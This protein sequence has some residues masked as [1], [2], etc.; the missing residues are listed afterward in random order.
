MGYS[1]WPLHFWSQYAVS[2]V[3]RYFVPGA[4]TWKNRL[5]LTVIS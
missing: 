5:H 1:V 3:L 2:R 4:W